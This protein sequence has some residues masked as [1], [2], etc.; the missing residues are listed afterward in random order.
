MTGTLSL[1]TPSSIPDIREALD[2]LLGDP[3]FQAS[4][5]L[6]RFLR[7]VVEE[8]LAGRAHRIKSYSIAVD[9]FGRPAN[10]DGV[11]DPIVRVEASR[12]RAALEEYYKGRANPIQIVIPKGSYI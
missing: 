2:D 4:G 10:F 8:T 12:L 7:F 5:R 3:E 11:A 6:K 1:T 9:V